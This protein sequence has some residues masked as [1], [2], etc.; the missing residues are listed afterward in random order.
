M[1]ITTAVKGQKGHCL[2]AAS[3]FPLTTKC[4]CKSKVQIDGA[5]MS[6]RRD[7]EMAVFVC[8][9]VFFFEKSFYNQFRS[10]FGGLK[11]V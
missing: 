4:S 10:D 3:I 7:N 2:G 11:A 9:G 1:K 5:E 8:F 6:K